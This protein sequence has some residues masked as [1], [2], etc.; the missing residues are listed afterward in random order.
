[1]RRRSRTESQGGTGWQA[2]RVG[3]RG[4]ATH[5][6]G[7]QAGGRQRGTNGAASSRRQAWRRHGRR[8]G[9]CGV[10]GRRAAAVGEPWADAARRGGTWVAL[11]ND[12]EVYRR[13]G[14]GRSLATN[15]GDTPV[16]V[17]YCVH[18]L[19]PLSSPR[20]GGGKPVQSSQRCLASRRRPD[21]T[22][23]ERCSQTRLGSSWTES[24]TLASCATVRYKT[25][26]QH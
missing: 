2:P 17:C 6:A 20:G 4:V 5:R 19:P 14:H 11:A 7:K 3:R 22:Q 13:N 23:Q 15:Q 10:G 1:M 16:V 8:V 25:L 12:V 26:K 9:R 24:R 18:P 21:R